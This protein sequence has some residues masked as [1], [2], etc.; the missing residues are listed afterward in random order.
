M[1]T[2]HLFQECLVSK[3]KWTWVPIVLKKV[4]VV[5]A[6]IFYIYNKIQ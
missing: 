5:L 4:I 3:S 6:A 1:E 2:G